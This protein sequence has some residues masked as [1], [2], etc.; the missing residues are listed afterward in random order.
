M[1]ITNPTKRY[2]L[3]ATLTDHVKDYLTVQPDVHFWKASDRFV[4]GIP[5]IV[6]CVGGIFVAAELKADN[7]TPT[8]QQELFILKTI[9]AGG[10]GGVCWCLQDVIDLIEEARRRARKLL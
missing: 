10:V 4:N 5:D 6:A 1:S 3:E 8:A 9:R 7:G 2:K